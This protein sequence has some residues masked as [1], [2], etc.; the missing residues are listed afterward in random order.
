[1]TK[2]KKRKKHSYHSWI[3]ALRP[4]ALPASCMPV[5]ATLA[6]LFWKGYDMNWAYG[7]L[8]LVGMILFHLTGNTWSDY[9]DYKKKVDAEDTFGAKSI[10]SGEFTPAEIKHVAIVLLILSVA[11]G[12]GIFAVTGLPVLWLGIAGVALT[13]L[14]PV[15]KYNALGDIDIL[16]TFGLLPA[17]GTAYVTTGVLDD[18]VLLA[19]VPVGLISVGILH[20]NNTRDMLTDQRAGI[21]TIALTLGNRLSALL[22]GFEVLFP[23]VW[24]GILSIVGYMPLHTIIIFMTIPVGVALHRTMKRSIKEGARPIIDLDARTANFQLVF[25]LLLAAAFVSARFI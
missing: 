4:W 1:M 8:A 24:V 19:G 22:Y 13:L 25:S 5:A 3:E 15:L 7:A 12:L 6:F 18:N 9:F 10:T 23:F 2:H 21:R 16:L 11:C 20:A 14:Y 17:L